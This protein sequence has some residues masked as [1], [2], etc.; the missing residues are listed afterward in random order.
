MK[1][2]I[3]ENFTLG[4]K[5]NLNTKSK[6][7]I[8]PTEGISEISPPCEVSCKSKTSAFLDSNLTSILMSL[9]TVYALF[10]DD[11]RNLS[12]RP[13]A[14][15]VFY[16]FTTIAMF[17]F[18]LELLLSSFAKV[19]YLW[20][21]YFWLD[22]VGTL[23]LIPDIGWLYALMVGGTSTSNLKG[24]HN[25]GK[26]SRAGTRSSRVVRIIRLIRLIRIVKLYK[27]ASKALEAN[28]LT[29]EET[30]VGKVLTDRIIKKV[31]MLILAMLIVLPF[32]DTS[33]YSTSYTSWEFGVLEL[34]NML[35]LQ[36]FS[37]VLEDFIEYH[38]NS[39]RPLIYLE[40]SNSTGDF[41]WENSESYSDYRYYEIFFASTDNTTSIFDITIDSQLSSALSICNTGF[42]CII[43]TIGALM[44]Y[45]DTDLHIIKPIE[46]MISKIK[47]ITQDPLGIHS[48]KQEI[49]ISNKKQKNC[50]DDQT[51]DSEYETL[52]IK[53]N[54][55][56]ISILLALGFG[57]AGSAIIRSNLAESGELNQ[58]HKGE[59]VVGI[60]AFCD[61]RNFTDATEELQEGI[62]VFVNEIAR[63]VH[64]IA[65]QYYGAANK[66][67]G[68]AFLIAWK[69]ENT[70]FAIEN[71]CIV[72]NPGSIKAF[73]YPDIALLSIVKVLIRINR[74]SNVLSYRSNAKLLKRMP[75]YS[76]K[77]GF[78]MHIGW[79]IEGALGSSYKID[80]S[81]LS[82]H[83]N[84]ASK[85]E[86][87]T[88]TY[89]IPLLI[90]G[91]LFNHFS[92]KIQILC[93]QVDRLCQE[94]EKVLDI[95][96]FDGVYTE[97]TATY[98]KLMSKEENSSK[99][100]LLKSRIV[101]GT[102]NILELFEDSLSIMKTRELFTQRFFKAYNRGFE[103]FLKN[104]WVDAKS[105]FEEVLELMPNDGPTCHLLQVMKETN[106]C[107]ANRISYL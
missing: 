67:I 13:S 6:S 29:T 88:K 5:S 40:Y 18:I 15:P 103:Y 1:Y 94:K 57:E 62:M 80:I 72:R 59:K 91:E 60:F 50:C 23:S 54:V 2:S 3:T 44:F 90:S 65:D 74:D 106:Y 47:Q 22:L 75:N 39:N 58:L 83:V 87:S 93:R 30:K 7:K 96:T 78:G 42:I 64:S 46:S 12:T 49:I 69:F 68:D 82:Q 76:V 11:I 84:L 66:N 52:I 32:L 17:F 85:L 104:R 25:A 20:S 41:I 79:A 107:P 38:E 37:I 10:G 89:G 26:A 100:T 102:L 71:D 95:Y 77:M 28:A 9:I 99:K 61:I 24:L 101:N 34:Q 35:N 98:K 56:K 73:V 43:L 51:N 63:I 19:D 36:G 48:N 27:G 55:E 70:D 45:K 8:V 81:Y 33:F 21:F 97:L 53:N 105:Y 86:A 92:K 16:S 31:I 14:D 4:K